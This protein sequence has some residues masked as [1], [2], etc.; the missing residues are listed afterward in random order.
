M[1]LIQAIL[2]GAL[3]GISEWLPISSQ[4]QL[5][6]IAIAFFNVSA[7][8][9]LK[10]SVMLHA[11]TLL[12]A[13][14]Y[15]R[16][17][18]FSLLKPEK[19]QLLWFLIIAVLSTAITGIPAYFFLKAVLGQSTA[20]FLLLIGFLLI[21]TGLIQ[22][23]K[24]F[25]KGKG[26][27]KKNAFFL[28]IAQGFSALPGISR[29]GMTVSAL[30]FEGF[31]PDEAFRLSFLLSIPSIAI[32]VLLFEAV[33]G[34]AV[35]FNAVIALIVSFLLGLLCIDLLLKAAKKISFS[36]FC[37]AFGIIYILIALADFLG[38]L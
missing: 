12:S 11:G 8:T 33:E 14:V 17:E 4:G 1:D 30:L 10:Y 7:E 13:I 15:F 29:S 20:F 25:R 5:M 21:A 3:Q 27:T 24:V 16:K 2:I 32:A 37:F 36:K 19:R 38:N 31:K 28:G 18:L 9:A 22:K 23:K 35:D 34:F 6:A 26:L